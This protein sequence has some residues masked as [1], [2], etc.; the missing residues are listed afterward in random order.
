M[1]LLGR[2]SLTLF[3]EVVG[4]SNNI[5]IYIYYVRGLN[6]WSEQ[7]FI[8]SIDLDFQM[9]SEIPN[10]IDDAQ[11]IIEFSSGKLSATTQGNVLN[12]E[13]AGKQRW[14]VGMASWNV[15]WCFWP[16]RVPWYTGVHMRI[17]GKW[18]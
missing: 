18:M 13:V 17:A 1:V 4:Y 10:E 15:F 3:L 5:Y 16:F 11:V 8:E 12:D 9:N 6:T 7:K 14:E 2:Q